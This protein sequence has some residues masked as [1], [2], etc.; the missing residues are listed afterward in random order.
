MPS[1]TR[2]LTVVTDL[3]PGTLTLVGLQGHEALSQLYAFQLDLVAASTTPVPF[4]QIVGRPMTVGVGA[5]RY[6][7]GIVSRLSEGARD[8][9]YTTYHAELVPNHWILTRRFRSRIF[10]DKAVP[11]IVRQVL[12]E[13]GVAATFQLERTYGHRN[14]VAQYNETDYDFITRLALDEAIFS[15]FRHSEAGE[16]LIYGDTFSSP[17]DLGTLPFDDRARSAPTPACSSWEKT[18]E[19]TSGKV[20]VR[21]HH[22]AVPDSPLEGTAAIAEAVQAGQ[23]T[24]RLRFPGSDDF[25]LYDY[26]GGYA[27]RFDGTSPGD[28]EQLAQTPARV[29]ADRMEEEAARAVVIRGSST[30]PAFAAG[31]RFGL[32]GHPNA[33]GAVRAHAGAALRL[34]AGGR[35]RRCRLPVRRTRSPASGRACRT[36]RRGRSTRAVV[37]GPQTGGR[38]RPGREPEARRSIRPREGAVLLGPRGQR[39]RDSSCWIRVVQPVGG[40]GGGF[41]WLPEV[42][43]E[44]VVAFEHGDPDRPLVIGR[45]YRRARFCTYASARLT[46]NASTTAPCSR[47][48]AST[49]GRGTSIEH[50]LISS[51]TRPRGRACRAARDVAEAG[52]NAVAA[53]AVAAEAADAAEAEGLVR[54]TASLWRPKPQLTSCSS[55]RSSPTA[56][57]R[58]I[59]DVASASSRTPPR[60]RPRRRPP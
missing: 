21:D 22:F 30:V 20:T 36:V 53:D 14:Y 6:F 9:R 43:D 35:E 41:F 56:C 8:A 45:V 32:S 24:H 7:H 44:V 13:L 12:G 38:R 42:G 37:H 2:Q 46:S 33:D 50:G 4:D 34:A 5:G 49:T 23:V 11:E 51:S 26:P 54:P 17:I 15:F 48:P 28:L 58:S 40:S 1:Q 25:E 57:G 55:S 27:Q 16:E 19:L 39:R 59:V 29:A 18:Q 60:H 3:A 31:F 10:Q 52:C 47:E